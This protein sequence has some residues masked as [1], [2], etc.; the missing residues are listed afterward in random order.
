MGEM[1]GMLKMAQIEYI[2]HLYEVEGKSLSY[3]AKTMHLDYRT[4]K[5]YA[6]CYDWIPNEKTVRKGRYPILGP[7]IEIIDEWLSED[8][9]Y[10][11]KQRH[12]AKRV[13]DRLIE[14]HKFGGSLRTVT[15][16]VCK[17]K[18][19]LYTK[20]QGYLPLQHDMG[21]AQVDFG[22]FVYLKSGQEKK[23]YYL[24]VSFPFSNA[25][26]L[27]VFKGQNQECV[28]EGLKRIFSRIGGVPRVLVMDN[29]KS[30][31]SKILPNGER[32]I[33][34]NFKRFALHYRFDM[35]FCNPA[36]GNEKGNVE[37]KVGYHRRNYFVPVPEIEDIEDFNNNL[38]NR[39][40][41]DMDR[42][43]YKKDDTIQELWSQEQQRLLYLPEHEFECFKL[44]EAAV[45][46]YGFVKFDN[47]RYSVN[48]NFTG[49]HVTIKIHYNELKIYHDHNLLVTYKRSYK[50]DEEIIDWK[51]YISLLS[52]KPGALEN[53]KFY[54]QI[55]KLWREHL[56]KVSKEEKKSALLLLKEI[57][58]KDDIERGNE[59]LMFSYEY[60]KYD[61]ESIKQVYYSLTHDTFNPKPAV[62][63]NDTPILDYNPE[64]S[65]YNSLTERLVNLNG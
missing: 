23:A 58:D 50:K 35:V 10:P 41:K 18:K 47:N 27:Q 32:E 25:A 19:E 60:G 22:E 65:A 33:S 59:A 15:D 53:T 48:P 21:E 20:Q 29:M 55:P 30:V 9:K 38:W 62:I 57:V 49:K 4:V 26:F 36:S 37:N 12:T 46:N 24:K 6:E 43:H 54:D 7:Y 16:Y 61:T 56:V 1:K 8:L 11:R 28:M 34:E 63:E 42:K 40:I 51:Q 44:V 17:K 2:K 45:D 3:I 14:E 31:V 64:L 52:K 39:S 13:Y 5:K